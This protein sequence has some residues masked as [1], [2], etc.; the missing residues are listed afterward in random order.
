MQK[1]IGFVVLI[2]FVLIMAGSQLFAAFCM[3]CRAQLPEEASFCHKCG[4]MQPQIQREE[5]NFLVSEQKRNPVAE[6]FVYVDEFEAFFE[7]VK[8]INVIGR[9]QE[10]KNKHRAAVAVVHANA[11]RLSEQQKLLARVYVAKFQILESIAELM[12]NLR[13]DPAFKDVLIRAA[14]YSIV[15]NNEILVQL[16][17]NDGMTSERIAALEEHFINAARR[18]QNYMVTSKYFQLGKQKLPTREALR[19]IE[20]KGKKALVLY[21]GL[22]PDGTHVERWASLRDLE[23]RTTWE[24]ANEELYKP[25]Q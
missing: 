15:Y 20:I 25:I 4:E 14:S 17:E 12:R 9:F 18:S 19:V 3:N 7:D 21:L 16:L 24:K 13:L 22:A 10:Y 6:T 11:H 23:R 5:Q 1:K 2:C 8:Y